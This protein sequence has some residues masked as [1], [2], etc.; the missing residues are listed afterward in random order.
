MPLE[1]PGSTT[2]KLVTDTALPSQDPK[3]VPAGGVRAPPEIVGATESVG[4]AVGAGSSVS[5]GS[6]VSVGS[7]VLVGRGRSVLVAVAVGGGVSVGV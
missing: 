1:G 5:A 4:A 3:A 2:R 6:G 7:R